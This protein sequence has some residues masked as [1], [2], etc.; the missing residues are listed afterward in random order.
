MIEVSLLQYKKQEIPKDVADDG[1]ETEVRLKQVEK[2][3]SPK[4]VTDVGM[5]TEVRS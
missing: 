3:L 5:E 2:Q 4:A 1:M